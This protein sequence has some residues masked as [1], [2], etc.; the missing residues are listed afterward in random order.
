MGCVHSFPIEIVEFPEGNS[1]KKN[2]RY[3][4]TPFSSIVPGPSH[5]L[6]PII[7]HYITGWWLTH[8]SEKYEFAS[9]DDDI[10]NI[11]EVIKAV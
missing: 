9:W 6:Y 4:I 5:P 8:P 7:S 10:S 3:T 1:T 2:S 11:W